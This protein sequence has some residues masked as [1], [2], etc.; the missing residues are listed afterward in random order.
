MDRRA[1]LLS[2]VAIGIGVCATALAILLLRCI[3]FSTNFFT[4][5]DSAQWVFRQRAVR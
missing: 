3:A 5:T 2:G 1:W 4:I